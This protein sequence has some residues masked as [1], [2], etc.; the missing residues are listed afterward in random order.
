MPFAEAEGAKLYYEEAGA[1][2][3]I[4]FVHEFAGDCASWEPQLRHFA[5]RYRCIAFNA[6]G[7]PPSEVPAAVTSY[8]QAI[9]ADDIAAVMRAA[10]I[11]RAHVVGLSMGGFAALHFG[12]RHPAMA[13]ALVVA[14]CGYGAPAGD[15][16]QFEEECAALAARFEDAGAEAVAE[17]YA[18]GPYR[19][20]F[21]N[22]DLRGWTE[23]KSRLGAHSA[24]GASLTLR[25][26]QALRPSLYDLEAELRKMTPPVLVIAGD[27]DEPCLEPSLFLKRMIPAA[28][29][30]VAPKSGHTVNLE[31]P[32]AF[33][34][35]LGD[36]FAAVEQGG[37]RARD[38]RSL[39]ASIIDS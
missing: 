15:R 11:G 9:A 7:Y 4:V 20:Q 28:G 35:A 34:R 22:K 32:G 10:G 1:G 33:N 24:A 18:M 31:E 36:F 37:W 2:Y 5:R 29:L 38:P 27:E 8:G 39:S 30:W 6:R 14:S 13:S 3:P 12:L 17:S 26:V 16:D 21:R 23:F 25:Q 19:I